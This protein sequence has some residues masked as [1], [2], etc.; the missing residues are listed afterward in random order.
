MVDPARP[1]LTVCESFCFNIILIC[2]VWQILWYKIDLYVS[3]FLHKF[4]Q[5]LLDTHAY[6]ATFMT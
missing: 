6:I 5:D 4:V 2:I 1:I 3:I